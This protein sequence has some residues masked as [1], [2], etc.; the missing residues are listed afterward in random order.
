MQ[1][2]QALRLFG[3]VVTAWPGILTA[4]QARRTVALLMPYPANDAEVRLRVEAFRDELQ[5]LVPA[6]RVL[7]FEERWSTDDLDRL[8]AD[9]VD[10]LKHD[11]DVIFFTGG[12]VALILQQVTSTTP[13]VFAGVSDPLGQG[14]VRSLA[15]P[16]RNLTGIASPEYTLTSK[17]L[18]LL[19]QFAPELDR[20]ALVTTSYNPSADFHRRQFTTAARALSVEP[21][22]IEI[23]S[24][25]EILPKFSRFHAERGGGMVVPSD[26]TLLADRKFLIEAAATVRVPVVYSDK[27]IAQQGGLISYSADRTEMFRQGARYVSRILKGEPVGALPIQQPTKFELVINTNT[28]RALGRV[29]P[30]TLLV[31]ADEVID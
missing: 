13:M 31:A 12:R 9:A 10:L 4:G 18:D 1:R 6:D 15:R 22:D 19:K 17:L 8:R 27:I 29:V 25:D 2:R 23:R 14:L 5:R 16:D 21:I 24:S 30:P 28:A 3:A 7:A 11:P 26:L 20:V